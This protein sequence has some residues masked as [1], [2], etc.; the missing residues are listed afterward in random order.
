MNLPQQLVE[1]VRSIRLLA[2]DV[3]G[4]MTDGGLIFGD[5]GQEYKRFHAFDGLGIKLL[6]Q[7]GV[8]IGVITGRK[9][10]VVA[11]RAKEIKA[12]ALY[13]GNHDKLPAF[14]DM[15]DKLSLSP[16]QIAFMGDDLIDLPVFNA[17]GLALSVPDAHPLVLRRA[18][19]ISTRQGGAGAVRDAC[20][21]I[22][23][24]HGNLQG[25]YDQF[26]GNPTNSGQ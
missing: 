8:K 22:M 3:D 14:Y 7:S 4:V 13:Q 10:E 20:E 11:R 26:L 9:S 21:L 23:E 18:D 25:V 2:L 24:C 1:K 6:I 19:W 15:C 12:S 17:A 16:G 5:D